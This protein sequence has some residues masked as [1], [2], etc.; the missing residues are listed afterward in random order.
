MIPTPLVV[1]ALTGQL[2]STVAG[3]RS[4]PSLDVPRNGLIDQ[5]PR[6]TALQLGTQQGQFDAARFDSV[7]ALS[8]RSYLD[9]A[10]EQGIPVVPL[11]NRALEGSA[12]KKSGADIMKAV[13]LL[14]A[15][16]A[17][18]MDVLGPGTPLTELEAGASALRSGIDEAT[19]ASIRA[20]RPVGTATIPLVVL[21]D[22]HQRGIPSAAARD[23]VTEIARMP[24]S[25]E[26]LNGLRETVAKNSVRGPGI[27]IQALNR[28]V[29]ITASG[30]NPASAPAAPD[31]KPIRP[32]SP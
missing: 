1:L 5:P 32:P 30:L 21:T 18:A 26:A 6:S 11:I 29:K 17:Q 27:A 2:L 12:R 16:L 9:T 13:R 31:R 8:L 10:M 14:G 3:S 28:Y 22:I 25:D 7:T 20:V 19:L 24:R 15:A 23:A 4:A